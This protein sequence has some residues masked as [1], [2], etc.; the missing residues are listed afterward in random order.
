MNLRSKYKVKNSGGNI[1]THEIFLDNLARRKEEELGLSEKKLEV[2]LKERIIYALFVVFLLV[3]FTFA[4]KT[5]Y[6]QVVE[7][8]KFFISA[9]NNK[10][11]ISLIRPE[12]GIIYD[13]NLKKLVLN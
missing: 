1:E 7:G 8:K 12:R 6:L 10:G 3:I 13:R 11:K 4:V 9:Q 5:F 2:P